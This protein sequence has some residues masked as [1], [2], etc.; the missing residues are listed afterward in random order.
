MEIV[1]LIRISLKMFATEASSNG[2]R[3]GMEIVVVLIRISLKMVATEASSNGG[4]GGEGD[5]ERRRVGWETDCCSGPGIDAGRSP[6]CW[7]GA[8]SGVRC[9]WLGAVLSGVCS[10]TGL[11]F[12]WMGAVCGVDACV[13]PPPE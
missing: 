10:T 1:V 8:V 3:G 9:P 6:P 7:F 5:G 11:T 4:M 12:P 13:R 2:G